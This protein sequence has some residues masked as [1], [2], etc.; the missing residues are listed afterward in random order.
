MNNL[1]L[2][3]TPPLKFTI[4]CY[5]HKTRANNTKSNNVRQPNGRSTN[6]ELLLSFILYMAFRQNLYFILIVKTSGKMKL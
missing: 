3:D 2:W 6:T 4:S 5:Q 1:P